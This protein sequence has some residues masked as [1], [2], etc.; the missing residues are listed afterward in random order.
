V[1]GEDGTY[2]FADEL[3]NLPSN[4]LALGAAGTP[5]NASCKSLARHSP[6]WV[7]GTPKVNPV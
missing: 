6:K 1:I 4:S 7:I 2:C 5:G 3:C